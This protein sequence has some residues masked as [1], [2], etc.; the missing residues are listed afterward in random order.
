VFKVL[1]VNYVIAKR[2]QS[3]AAQE[4]SIINCQLCNRE[5]LAERSGARIMNY[6]L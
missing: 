4:L 2:L 5:A 1:I 3:E 6:E